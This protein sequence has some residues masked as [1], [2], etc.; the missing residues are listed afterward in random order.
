[1]SVKKKTQSLLCFS[2]NCGYHGPNHSAYHQ[3][4]F[5]VSNFLFPLGKHPH[6][7]SSSC[8]NLRF[9]MPWLKDAS[10]CVGEERRRCSPISSFHVLIL[11]PVSWFGPLNCDHCNGQSHSCSIQSHHLPI[12]RD[13]SIMAT[14]TKRERKGIK[15]H[16]NH[17]SWKKYSTW[18]E[19]FFI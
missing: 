14:K 6:F 2:L 19:F 10:C 1:M 8:H 5:S 16:Q 12:L 13:Y 11:T 7:K 9:Q 15:N 18:P 4:F 3:A 17:V